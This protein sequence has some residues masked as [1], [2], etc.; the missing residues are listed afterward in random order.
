MR[1]QSYSQL[2]HRVIVLQ[3][4]CIEPLGESKSDYQIFLG[5]A[6]RLGLSAVFTEG[7]TEIDWCK[8]IFEGSDVSQY[9]SW[10]EFLKKG[11]YVVP[12]EK[13]KLR[14]PTAYRWFYEGRKKDVPEPHPLPG[15]L[16]R[17]LARRPANPERQ[18][19]VRA[20]EP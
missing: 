15:R 6:K 4:K 13:E 19:R 20:R 16:F 9:I 7:M 8:R 2:N 14:A 10:K 5:L 3:H 11:Y 1:H 17:D 18:V 12:A